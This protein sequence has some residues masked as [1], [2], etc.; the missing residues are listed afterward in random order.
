MVM[1]SDG[2]WE[3]VSDAEAIQGALRFI[4]DR[5]AK[6]AAKFL[7]SLVRPTPPRDLRD[8]RW[9]RVWERVGIGGCGARTAGRRSGGGERGGMR[10][11][12]E[13]EG[14]ECSAGEMQVDV[15]L[16]ELLP[17][18]F[19]SGSGGAGPHTRAL[20]EARVLRGERGGGRRASGGW[21]EGSTRMT[22]QPSSRSS[23]GGSKT[24]RG[25]LWGG[26]E[27]ASAV[28]GKGGDRQGAAAPAPR[29]GAA[30]TY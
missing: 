15:A 30:Y 8:V 18:L 21:S 27:R 13:R 11:C 22:S 19:S 3:F 6:D 20:H 17:S 23:K 10:G 5:N 14:D 12:F 9:E 24:D 25:M 1:G 28:D 4:H 7:T 26:A 2:L 29:L 16:T